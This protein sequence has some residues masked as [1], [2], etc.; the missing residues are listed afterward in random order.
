MISK[1]SIFIEA[2]RAD[3]SVNLEDVTV[4]IPADFIDFADNQLKL[5][6]QLISYLESETG[7]YSVENIGKLGDRE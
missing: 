7:G 5:N 4:D 3:S 1:V 6:G 2:P